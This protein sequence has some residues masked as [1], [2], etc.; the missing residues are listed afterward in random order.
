[1]S[2]RVLT[3]ESQRRRRPGQMTFE[4]QRFKAPWLSWCSSVGKRPSDAFRALVAQ[5]KP[6][7]WPIASERRSPSLVLSARSEPISKRLKVPLTRGEWAAVKTLADHQEIT[8]PKWIVNLVRAHLSD[9]PQLGPSSLEALR[10]SNF[11]LSAIGKNVNQIA[12]A[13]NAIVDHLDNGRLRQADEAVRSQKPQHVRE[14]MEEVK[15]MVQ[16]H[17]PIVLAVLDENVARWQT[18]VNR[19]GS[20]K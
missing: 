19:D 5:L 6:G 15:G 20:A 1:M 3:S 12:R 18:R 9:R 11:Q 13:L 17:L 4:L 14:L 2:K 8:G 7:H 16:G 10:K